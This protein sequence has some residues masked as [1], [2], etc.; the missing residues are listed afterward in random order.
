MNYVKL[1]KELR[2]EFDK[3]G[4]L[5]TAAVAAAEFSMSLSYDVPMLSRYLDFINVMAYDL[6]GTWDGF[7]G[8]N[9]P[10]YPSSQDVEET[11]K[12]LNVVRVSLTS[13]AYLRT[14][15]HTYIYE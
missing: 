14:Y 2:E 7:T 13:L 10:L 4:Y 11:S 8:N 6:H 5:L 9:A 15:V 3:H 1:C 12:Q